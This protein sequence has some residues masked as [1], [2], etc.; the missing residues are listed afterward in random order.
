MDSQLKPPLT[1]QPA[2]VMLEKPD[3]EIEFKKINY[4]R[5]RITNGTDVQRNV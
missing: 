2:S 4:D 5:Q 1:C 3:T